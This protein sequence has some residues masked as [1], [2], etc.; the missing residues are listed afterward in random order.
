M[1]V[2]TSTGSFL[3]HFVCGGKRYATM[4]FRNLGGYDGL[5]LQSLGMSGLCRPGE[6][7]AVWELKGGISPCS[8]SQRR[9]L[10][11][12]DTCAQFWGTTRT[13]QDG[14]QQG[15]RKPHEPAQRSEIGSQL[16][17]TFYA[18]VRDLDLTYFV[19]NNKPSKYFKEGLKWSVHALEKSYWS[20]KVGLEGEELS[21]IMRI[22][23]DKVSV[24]L[25][26]NPW[27]FPFP[28]KTSK[29]QRAIPL[30]AFFLLLSA[31]WTRPGAFTCP[32]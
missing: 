16:W 1:Y 14:W 4:V 18:L 6:H 25:E 21:L 17:G 3:Q 10:I 8:V 20:L 7:S 32:E 12:K 24:S 22:P 23:N 27:M 19:N 31:Q 2:V 5:R 26:K 30:G 15:P 28:S 11:G 13:P 29:F 9:P